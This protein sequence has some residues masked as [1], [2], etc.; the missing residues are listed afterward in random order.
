MAMDAE[1]ISTLTTQLRLMAATRQSYSEVWND[2]ERSRRGQIKSVCVTLTGELEI[3]RVE[4]LR[5]HAA[6]PECQHR[7]T[8][9]LDRAVVERVLALGRRAA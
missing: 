2:T 7:R 6:I 5:V 9:G 8:I 3:D 4:D 1:P